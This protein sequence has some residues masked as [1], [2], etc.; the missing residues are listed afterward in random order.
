MLFVNYNVSDILIKQFEIYRLVN[1]NSAL[2]Y[3]PS[4]QES[5]WA[6]PREN[7]AGAGEEV[8]D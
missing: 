1:N 2:L 7:G 8:R 3:L 5:I 4:D 6:M